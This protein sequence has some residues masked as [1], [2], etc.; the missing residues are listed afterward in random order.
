MRR[1]AAGREP[2]DRQRRDRGAMKITVFGAG[3]VGGLIAGRLAQAGETTSVVARG[4]TLAAI[5]EH[6]L[7]LREGDGDEAAL[8]LTA[9]DDPAGLPD[10]DVVVLALKAHQIEG[11]LP[12]IAPLLKGDPLVLPAINGVPWWYGAGSDSPLD[13]A[14]I[15]AVDPNGRL[16]DTFDAARLA[17]CVVY[18]AAESPEPGR[19]VSTGNRRLMLGPVAPGGAAGLEAFATA[20]DQAGFTAPVV[21]D[22][23]VEVWK[24]LWGNLWAN[25][26]SVLTNAT[27][28]EI[29]SEPSVRETARAMMREARAVAAALGVTLDGDIDERIDK[30]G[31]GLPDFRTSMLQDF[32][33]GRPIEL[34]AILGAVRELAIRLEIP[35]PTIDMVY[36]LTRL[37]ARTAN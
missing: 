18:V 32:D 17:G 3:A 36:G 25:P 9:T 8:P 5:R 6:G 33:R 28:G 24:K 7:R 29:A 15:A 27:M 26:I 16:A 12:T 30:P 35:A 2:K 11:A 20:L 10:Q 23:R 19:V 21:D 13:P 22:I 31:R 34:E 1:T 4:A 14:R 37:R